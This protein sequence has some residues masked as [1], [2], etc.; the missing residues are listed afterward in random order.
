MSQELWGVFREFSTAAYLFLIDSI[1]HQDLLYKTYFTKEQPKADVE[2]D[3]YKKIYFIGLLPRH[4]VFIRFYQSAA[5]KIN[6]NN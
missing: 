4:K 2:Y 6:G 5:T 3:F 1:D